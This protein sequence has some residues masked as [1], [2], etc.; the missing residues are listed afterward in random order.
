MLKLLRILVVKKNAE[1]KKETITLS[2]PIIKFFFKENRT[3]TLLISVLVKT[4]AQ[5][6]FTLIQ[7]HGPSPF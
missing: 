6:C 5:K 1:A 2:L 7:S 3:K 4:K